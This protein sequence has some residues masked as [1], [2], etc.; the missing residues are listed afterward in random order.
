MLTVKETITALSM[1]LCLMGIIVI[2]MKLANKETNR[3]RQA[4]TTFVSARDSLDFLIAQN[5]NCL[6]TIRQDRTIP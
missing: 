5:A 2:G 4:L 3:C 1:W 6:A